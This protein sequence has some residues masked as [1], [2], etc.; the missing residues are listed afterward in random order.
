MSWSV[1]RQ[2]ALRIQRRCGEFETL[3]AR[4]DWAQ[5]DAVTGDRL[6]VQNRRSLGD[7]TRLV[8][9]TNAIAQRR[10][11]SEYVKQQLLE[12]IRVDIRELSAVH[13]WG[14]T[15]VVERLIEPEL[16]TETVAIDIETEDLPHSL[17]AVWHRGDISLPLEFHLSHVVPLRRNLRKA[18]YHV[19][20]KP[21]SHASEC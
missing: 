19:S 15:S 12:S 21:T 20:L 11:D 9:V 6:R 8:A 10:P 5:L 17:K 1:V 3:V 2:L 13:P 4:G 7:C 16:E 14:S 18:V